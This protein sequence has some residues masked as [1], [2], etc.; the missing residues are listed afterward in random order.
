MPENYL[1]SPK[2]GF[3]SPDNSWFKGDS[4]EFVRSILDNEHSKLYQFFD[5]SVVR[6]MVG[7]HLS[8]TKNRRLFIWSLLNFESWCQHFLP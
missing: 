3:S 4:I 2:Q 1:N 7:E 8:G 5:P 6:D